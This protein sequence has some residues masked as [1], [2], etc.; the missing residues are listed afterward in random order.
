MVLR[1]I[2]YTNAGLSQRKAVRAIMG[3]STFIIFLPQ[4]C[5]LNGYGCPHQ[6]NSLSK[7]AVRET[8]IFCLSLY[9]KDM[10]FKPPSLLFEATEIWRIVGCCSVI[11]ETV[12]CMAIPVLV[13]WWFGGKKKNL[14]IVAKSKGVLV[15][16]VD[17]GFST[18]ACVRIMTE[19]DTMQGATIPE[20]LIIISL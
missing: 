10:H 6:P 8:P 17:Q 1:L 12:L 4:L 5:V 3:F 2:F 9:L 11:V 18:L 20:F 16:T 7:N 19:T 13:L 15:I 14:S